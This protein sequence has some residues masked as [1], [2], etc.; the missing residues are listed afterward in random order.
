MEVVIHSTGI[1]YFLLYLKQ[2]ICHICWTIFILNLN[3]IFLYWVEINKLIN[4]APYT[5][6]FGYKDVMC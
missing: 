5:V 6:V 3:I 1:I 4:K 2:Y